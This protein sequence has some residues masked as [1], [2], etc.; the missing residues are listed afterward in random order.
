MTAEQLRRAA[1]HEAHIERMG[2]CMVAAHGRYEATGC[3]G[4][5][6]EADGYRIAME[7]AIRQRSPAVVAFMEVARGLA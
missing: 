3:F 2:N 6:G 7:R 5:K 1:D 4:A